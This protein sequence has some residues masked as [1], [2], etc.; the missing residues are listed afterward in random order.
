MD[1]E[2]RTCACP[3]GQT[4]TPTHPRQKYV[5]ASHRTKAKSQRVETKPTEEISEPVQL[6]VEPLASG[7]TIDVDRGKMEPF[8][9]TTEWL[10]GV[11]KDCPKQNVVVGGFSFSLTTYEVMQSPDNPKAGVPGPSKPGQLN[12]MTEEQRE[13]VIAA[14]DNRVVRWASSERKRGQIVA[15]D[16]TYY[17][18][19][20]FDEPLSR[21][22]WM[23]DVAEVSF[24][25]VMSLNVPTV[26]QQ[27]QTA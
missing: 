26:E 15:K 19:E 21:Y 13:R 3:C 1:E 4:F 17:R 11:A 22:L 6:Q 23:I 27:L 9:A 5:D 10:C 16:M 24:G 20:P 25:K 8:G 7:L 2:L 14:I 18:P 12:K